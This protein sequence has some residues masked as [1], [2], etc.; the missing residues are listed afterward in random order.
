MR[1]IRIQQLN[2]HFGTKQ[3]L[4][5]VS[6]SVASKEVVGLI[7]PSGCGKS[8]LLRCINR[9]HD[10][11]ADAKIKGD[12]F[13]DDQN[14]YHPTVDPNELRSKVGMVF[15]KPNPFPKSVFD[16][17]A[18]GLSIQGI[19]SK[20]RQ[21]DVVEKSLRE[22]FLWD[23]VKDKL[24]EPAF[25]L[26]GGQQ[27]RLCIARTIA[28]QPEVIL[29]DEPTSALD[30]LATEKIEKLIHSLKKHYTIIIV[31]HNMQQAQRVADKIAMLYL[32]DLVEFTDTH[33]FFSA[34][35]HD[36]A[37]QYVSGQFG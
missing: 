27:Q 6:F 7:G 2:L 31:T 12:I 37:K 13:I 14:I 10:H 25:S 3:V 29:M 19:R 11:S 18:Y 9:M 23:E 16:N 30:P 21:K 22:A 28:I 36:L 15:Q 35:E 34:P 1:S 32:G 33:K 17:V 4:K 8:T 24:N 20:N 26:S 5:D